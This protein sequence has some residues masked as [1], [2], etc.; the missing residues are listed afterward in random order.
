MHELYNDTR[1]KL[2]AKRGA[3]Q[4]HLEMIETAI[5]QHNRHFEDSANLLEPRVRVDDAEAFDRHFREIDGI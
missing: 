2:Y 4:A 3:L 5:Q 1:Y